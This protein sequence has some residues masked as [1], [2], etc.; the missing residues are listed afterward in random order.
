VTVEISNLDFFPRD[1]TVEGNASV[2]WVNRDAVP[3]D[4]TG[5]GRGWGTDTLMPGEDATL[6]FDS[7]GIYEYVCTIHPNMEA[8]LT[9]S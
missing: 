2:T 9:V 4:A 1:L 3:H 5:V 7:P 6:T 8:T